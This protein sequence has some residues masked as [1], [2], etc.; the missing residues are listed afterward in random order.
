MCG[1][2]GVISITSAVATYTGASALLACMVLGIVLVNAT[3]EA[4]PVLKITNMISPPI[5]MIFFV[6]SGAELD[7]ALIPSIG[8]IGIIYITF[9]VLG[10]LLGARLGATI[11]K[12]P[13]VV[14]K[15]LGWTLIPQAGVALG[16]SLVAV[17]IVPE[18]SAQ[19]RTV[20]LCATMIYELVGPII[21]KI[22]LTKAGEINPPPK[23][24]A[25]AKK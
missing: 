14:Q 20:V 4:K 18:Y 19:I 21:S 12:A 22:A 24:A 13:D 11:M 7:L 17:K 3:N 23:Q 2:L 8:A 16:L 25:K 10:K 5:F 15:Y 9:R 1:I 6:I